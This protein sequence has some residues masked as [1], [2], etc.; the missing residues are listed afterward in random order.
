MARAGII[1]P[2]LEYMA[3]NNDPKATVYKP[4]VYKPADK[5]QFEY[6]DS[7]PLTVTSYLGFDS[8]GDEVV[9]AK[10]VDGS[11]FDVVTFKHGDHHHR[12]GVSG[13]LQDILNRNNQ[14]HRQPVASDGNVDIV[15]SCC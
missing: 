14:V 5:P 8:G 2:R 13:L 1:L 15:H 11:S 9:E 12:V 4:P 3:V 7:A 10:P 6:I